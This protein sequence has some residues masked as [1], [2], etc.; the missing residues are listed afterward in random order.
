MFG[1]QQTTGDTFNIGLAEPLNQRVPNLILDL[2]LGISYGYQIGSD[3][4]QHSN[5]DV[6]DQRMTSCAGGQ[7][8]GY[9]ANGGLITVGGI[10]DSNANPSDPYACP[11]G[12][13]WDDEL[14]SLL[15][16]VKDGDTKIKIDTNN[17]SNDDSIYFAA[18][19]LGSTTAIVGEGIVLAPA[20][21]SG[22]IN[23]QHSV[24][25]TVQDDS[26]NPVIGRD[27]AFS[28]ISG[29]NAGKNVVV[30]TDGA[31]KA[32]Y[33]Y[34]GTMVGIDTIVE[35]FTNSNGDTFSSNEVKKEWTLPPNS[36]PIASCKNA[37][38][39]LD[40]SGK[41]EISASTVDGGSVDP[42]GDNISLSVSKTAFDCSNVGPNSVTLTVTDDKG[43]SATCEA[44]VT[45][46]DKTGPTVLTK[47][48]TVQLDASGK[49]LINTSDIDNG[50]SD[51]CGIASLAALPVDFTCSHIG[52][53]TVTL[54]A[55]DKSGNSSSATATV[56]VVDTLAPTNVQANAPA[57]I[58]P[59]DAPISFKATAMDN[60]S[61]TVKITEYSCYKVKKDGS[62]QSKMES[63]VVNLSGDTHT[64]TVADSGG[65]GNNIVWTVLATDQSGNTATANGSVLVVTPSSSSGLGNNGVGNGQ[66]PQ[67]LGN[68]PVNDGPGTSPGNPGNKKK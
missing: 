39:N 43:A 33:S 50:T 30:M 26:G 47:D 64:L 55:T 56:T 15:P 1:A 6:N 62:Q 37:T 18:L 54:A 44:A 29:P 17:P 19:F 63:C 57:T 10:G 25:A 31:G 68:P 35:K 45:V 14:Y 4:S 49:A 28:I 12:P 66:D 67:P 42:D 16:F 65:V 27:V 52:A 60:C 8:D 3:T 2:S 61:A 40:H 46:Q 9:A 38:V 11:S 58:T 48:V 5:I 21:A 36:L 23:K 32:V 24:T 7:D 13:R 51:A 20:T 41:A 53:N 59:P 34:T 22:E